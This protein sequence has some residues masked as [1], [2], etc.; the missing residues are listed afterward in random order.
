METLGYNVILFPFLLFVLKVVNIRAECE[1]PNIGENRVL[2]SEP[3]KPPYLNG[4]TATFRCSY[5]YKAVHFRASKSIMCIDGQ[6]TELKLQCQKRSCGSLPDIPNGKFLLEQGI[7]FGATAVAECNMG[8]YLVGQQYRYCENSGWSG[9]NPTCEVV[10]CLEPPSI[11][12]GELEDVSYEM[13][14]YGQA[15]TYRCKRGF[16]LIGQATISCS[17]NGTFDPSPP[18]CLVVACEKPNIPNGKRVEGTMPP[19]KYKSSLRYECQ[20]GYKM[21]GSGTMVCEVSGWVPPLV[22]C[23]VITCPAPPGT[24]NGRINE[25]LRGVYTYGQTVTY[26][27]NEGFKLIGASERTCS[28]DETFQRSPPQCQVITCPAPPGIENGRINEPLRDVY[29]YGQ[30]VTYSCMKGFKLIGASERTCS[31][32]ETFQPS[33]PW[34][35]VITCPAPP[36]IE[37]GR[38]N[39]PLRGV[40]TYGQTVTYSCNEGFKLIGASERT[41]SGD[42]TFQ[43]SAPR[44]QV[45]TCP[46]P[47]GIENGQINEPLQDVYTYG[48]TVTYSCM[49]GFKLIGAS[50]RTCSGDETFQPSAPRCQVLKCLRP[51]MQA[52]QLE[53]D[54]ESYEYGQEVIYHCKILFYNRASKAVC[55]DEGDFIPTPHCVGHYGILL[56]ISLVLLLLLA[57]AVVYLMKKKKHCRRVYSGKVAT[58]IEE[59]EL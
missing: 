30:A 22:N 20:L 29:T 32:D 33:P 55:S 37:N 39:E 1:R 36:G 31:G 53:P 50:K 47:P 44:C 21:N 52:G 17:I 57:A 48:Q 59:C 7:E 46:A 9:R 24:E 25:P 45:I 54:Q 43:P 19:Y 41:C 49:K 3:D 14:E 51:H 34:C 8:Y 40:Y 35:Q 56:F 15:V 12:N 10:K 5:G 11:V 27:C 42:E 58:I 38:I 23:T 6:W 18:Q 16:T 26:S 2:T 4:S 28:G 13:Y